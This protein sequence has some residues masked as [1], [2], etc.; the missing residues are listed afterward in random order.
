M[1]NFALNRCFSRIW[2][3]SSIDLGEL[4]E[5]AQFKYQVLELG[6]KSK[7]VGL[8]TGHYRISRATYYR[9]KRQYNPKDPYSLEEC[10]KRP[11]RFRSPQW[12]KELEQAVKRFRESYGWG[13]D[14]LAVLVKREGYETSTSTVGRILGHLKRAGELKEAPRRRF[15]AQRASNPRRYAVRKPKDYPVEEPGDLVQL[16]TLDLNRHLSEHRYQFTARD[17]IS[18]WDVLEAH[19]RAGAGSAKNFL[20][21]LKRECPFR[22]KAIQVDGGSEFY[23][24]FETACKDSDIRLF[25]LPPRSPKLNGC[26]ERANRTH[27]EEYYEFTDTPQDLADHNE[28]LKYWQDV[29][30]TVRP[31]HSLNLKTPLEIVE[32]YGIVSSVPP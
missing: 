18:R 14:K 8:T 15:K 16:D 17:M 32:D 13:K 24:I 31:H 7:D 25:V 2:K 3:Y 26:V 12:T 20:S 19:H 22:V 1:Q 5:K 6:R 10:S 11:H 27:R 23:S 4:S 21:T 29:Y 9:W 28:D 30:N